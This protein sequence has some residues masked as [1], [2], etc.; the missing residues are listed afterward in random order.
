MS[1]NG[2]F[3]NFGGALAGNG[4]SNKIYELKPGARQW[5]SRPERMELARQSPAVVPIPGYLLEC[6]NSRWPV[7]TTTETMVT[8]ADVNKHRCDRIPEEKW[9][10]T[11]WSFFVS[12]SNRKEKMEIK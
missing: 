7:K 12:C 11:G 5:I 4:R 3:F 6:G 10:H 8:P 9:Q 1:I 2:N